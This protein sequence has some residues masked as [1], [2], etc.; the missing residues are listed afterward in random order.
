ME[1]VE[2]PNPSARRASATSFFRTIAG[3]YVDEHELTLC[4]M[5]VTPIGTKSLRQETVPYQADQLEE[6]LRELLSPFLT[7]RGVRVPI[8]V[9]L[10]MLRVIFTSR[11]LPQNTKDPAPDVLLHEAMRSSNVN[12]DDME[13]DMIKSQPGK[14]PLASLTACRRRYLAGLLSA[15]GSCGVRPYRAEPSPFALVRLAASRYKTPRKSKAAIRI[16][17]GEKQGVA[18]LIASGT[19]MA[20]RTFELAA[21]AEVSTVISAVKALMIVGRFRGEIPPADCVLIHGR[22]DLEYAFQADAFQEATGVQTRYYKDPAFDAGSVAL[23]LAMGCQQAGA[24][25][26]LARALKPPAPLWEL[27]PFGELATQIVLLVSITLYLHWRQQAVSRESVKIHAQAAKHAWMAKI[28]E[29]KIEAEKKELGL[30]LEAVKEYLDTRILWSSYTRDLASN[31]PESIVL[32]AFAGQCDLEM[33]PKRAAKPKKSLVFRLTAPITGSR[34]MPKEID[35]YLDQLRADPLMSR[36]FPLIE[37]ADLKSMQAVGGRAAADFTVK[38]LPR[39][40]GPAPK[41]AAT[42]KKEQAKG[43]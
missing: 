38:C 11:P 8:A 43:G 22:P 32:R 20:W 35:A 36:D 6:T 13:V 21:G 28:D 15:L 42:A 5:A 4:H 39:T 10:P 1:P 14:Q 16:V 3:L 2:T 27:I 25:F 23:G 9:G 26:D 41:A 34:V 17:L 30:K 7:K 19:P 37:I 12:V 18:V 24:S 31:V 40:E 33:G 29:K